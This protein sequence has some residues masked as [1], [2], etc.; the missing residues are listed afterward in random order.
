[1]SMGVEFS[2]DEQLDAAQSLAELRRQLRRAQRDVSAWKW[3]ILALHSAVR[4]LSAAD[5][6]ISWAPAPVPGLVGC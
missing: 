5:L 1:M 6:L 2:T 3:A 4:M